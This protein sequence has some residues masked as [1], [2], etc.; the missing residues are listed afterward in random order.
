MLARHFTQALVGAARGSRSGT[1]PSRPTEIRGAAPWRRVEQIIPS[2]RISAYLPMGL[3]PVP[4]Q[5]GRSYTYL[6][7]RRAVLMHPPNPRYGF[8]PRTDGVSVRSAPWIDVIIPGL[9]QRSGG[10]RETSTS[11]VRLLPAVMG[12]PTIPFAP[13]ASPSLFVFKRRWGV[14]VPSLS[15]CRSPSPIF[16]S[17]RGMNGSHGQPFTAEPTAQC[18]WPRWRSEHEAVESLCPAII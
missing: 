2:H 10:L 4:T 16:G 14:V 3:A 6:V 8:H 13:S 1:A 17:D 15:S 7:H 18:L 12:D 5:T 11:F 9:I